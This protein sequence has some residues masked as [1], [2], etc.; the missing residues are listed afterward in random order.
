M[1]KRVFKLFVIVLLVMAVTS[2]ASSFQVEAKSKTKSKTTVYVTSVLG[3]M[4]SKSNF[5]KT[6]GRLIV[7]SDS[8]SKHT[9]KKGTHKR[10]SEIGEKKLNYK[11]AKNCKWTYSYVT[12]NDDQY[13]GKSSYKRIKKSVKKALSEPGWDFLIRIYVKDKRIVRVDTQSP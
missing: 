8:W 7:Y 2:V 6:N 4:P 12:Y 1:N 3:L 11:I 9:Y 13:E 10:G 5:K